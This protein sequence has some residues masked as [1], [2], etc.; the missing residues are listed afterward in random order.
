MPSDQVASLLK[1]AEEQFKVAL[2]EADAMKSDPSKAAVLLEKWLTKFKGG[3]SSQSSALSVQFF[4]CIIS[5][6]VSHLLSHLLKFNP[7]HV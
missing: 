7:L 5:Y 2:R 4:M 6:L 3:P 1:D